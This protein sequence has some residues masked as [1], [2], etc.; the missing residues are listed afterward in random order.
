MVPRVVGERYRLR[1]RLAAGGVGEVWRA[2]D[3]VLGRTVAVKLLRPEHADSG[4]YRE[5]LRLEGRH[6]AALSHPHLAEVYDHGDGENGRPFIAMELIDGE[7][8]SALLARV[9]TL[10]PRRV[11]DIVAQ[12]ADGLAC[13]HAAALVHRDM[14]PANLLIRPD[15]SV[16]ITDF[17]IARG[18][19]TLRLTRT[20]QV[21][22]TPL[23]LAPEQ[24]AGYGVTPAGDLYSLGVIAWECLAGRP[25]FQGDDV[26]A[27]AL[28]HRD[29]P[30]P[31]LPAGVPEPVRTL[32]EA[33]TAKDPAA[34]PDAVTVAEQARRLRDDPAVA[35]A[36]AGPVVAAEEEPRFDTRTGA[37]PSS[38]NTSSRIDTGS[39]SPHR[40]SLLLGVGVVA[41]A[42]L[43]GASGWALRTPSDARA[44]RAQTGGPAPAPSRRTVTVDPADYYGHRLASVVEALR[45]QGLRVSV[46]HQVV[47]GRSAGTVVG[48][49]PSG[50]VPVGATVTLY[51]AR[52]LASPAPAPRRTAQ[53]TSRTGGSAEK[54]RTV[55]GRPPRKAPGK[56]EKAEGH[57]RKHGKAGPPAK[58]GKD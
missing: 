18:P 38:A 7:P 2:E 32:V 42:A 5:R 30:V 51:A 39:A 24:A 46:R 40:R 55:V 12:A 29:R 14:K 20:G 45:R 26:L 57:G 41:V 25:P 31:P 15:G 36:P 56:P 44:V 13:V 49:T 43:T 23:Y 35:A 6:L 3:T 48:L 54:S 34:R 19:E 10:P 37:V 16:K 33:L 11:A 4:E 52:A 47:P 53:A 28:A 58:H 50:A 9:R 22:G 1:E 27:V 21:I 17:G 8:L